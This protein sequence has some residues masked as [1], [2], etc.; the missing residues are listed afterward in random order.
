MAR[1]GDSERQTQNRF[2]SGE[3]LR[4]WGRSN[5]LTLSGDRA[6]GD[7]AGTERRDAGLSAGGQGLNR[8][9]FCCFA[10]NKVRLGTE[11]LESRQRV[12]RFGF[13]EER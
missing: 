3:T 13:P 7:K 12:W 6:A 4:V 2:V 8:A 5:A 11:C 10:E 1:I 9:F